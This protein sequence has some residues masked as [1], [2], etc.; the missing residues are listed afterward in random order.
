MLERTVP[1]PIPQGRRPTIRRYELQLYQ[2]DWGGWHLVMT[3]TTAE[4]LETPLR[5]LGWQTGKRVRVV[6]PDGRVVKEVVSA[7]RTQPD[8]LSGGPPERTGN[9]GTDR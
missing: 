2:P 4:V 7:E 9:D 8:A 3:A 5:L 1:G 6:D